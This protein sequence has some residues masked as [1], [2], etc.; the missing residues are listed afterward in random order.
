MLDAGHDDLAGRLVTPISS[1]SSPTLTMPRSIRPVAT[2]PPALDPEERSSTGIRNGLSIARL[3]GPG[4]RVDR[5]HQLLDRAVG[6]I[7]GLS[8]GLEGLQGACRG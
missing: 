2:V 8:A 4:C 6:R 3:G 5:V 1:T 7:V